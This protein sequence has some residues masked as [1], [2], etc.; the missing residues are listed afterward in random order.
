MNL[1]SARQLVGWSA[2]RAAAVAVFLGV[3]LGGCFGCGGGAPA[4]A[5][6]V[7]EEGGGKQR[8]MEFK[9]SDKLNT[10]GGEVG[11]ALVVKVYQLRSDARISI[12][13]LSQFWDNEQAEL[14]EDFISAKEVVLDPSGTE[15]FELITEPDIKFLAVVGNYCETQGD[16]WRWIIP[17]DRLQDHTS[18]TFN[19]FCIEAGQ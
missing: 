7:V 3:S 16:C 14:A 17:A 19:E 11:R 15:T 4:P 6:D 10:C 5:V 1:M 13:S 18:L 2:I 9:A 8:S 12:M